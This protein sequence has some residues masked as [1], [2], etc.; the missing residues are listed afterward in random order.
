MIF[1]GRFR[2]ISGLIVYIGN[3][4]SKLKH[5][6]CFTVLFTRS[7]WFL[8]A[9]KW[10]L[11]FW[12]PKCWKVE[13]E[14]FEVFCR[15]ALTQ[16][17]AF[18]HYVMYHLISVFVTSRIHSKI[19]YLISQLRDTVV[20]YCNTYWYIHIRIHLENSLKLIENSYHQLTSGLKNK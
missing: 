13:M 19:Y 20:F 8:L 3:I 1:S 15:N 10:F 16:V 18:I 5:K 17:S 2:G 14:L 4:I 11:G 9:F 12:R 6:Q 7:G